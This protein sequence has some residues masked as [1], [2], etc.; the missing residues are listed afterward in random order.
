MQK[1]SSHSRGQGRLSLSTMT[2]TLSFLAYTA[3]KYIT[4]NLGGFLLPARRDFKLQEAASLRGARLFP[5]RSLVP[6]GNL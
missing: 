6:I 2:E 1:L 4:S 5:G 3:A